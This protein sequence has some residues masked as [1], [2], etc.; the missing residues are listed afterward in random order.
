M[1]LRPFADIGEAG[2]EGM[3]DDPLVEI[4][5]VHDFETRLVH[6]VIGIEVRVGGETGGGD[7]VHDSWMGEAATL[8]V[9]EDINFDLANAAGK[10]VGERC[11]VVVET[12]EGFGAGLL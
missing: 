3:A 4:L 6:L 5:D 10:L 7:L 11:M 12:A 1:R 9:D 2:D 8:L